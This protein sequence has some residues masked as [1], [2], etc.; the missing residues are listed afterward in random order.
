MN[1]DAEGG[2]WI[3]YRPQYSTAIQ[4]VST[5]LQFFRELDGKEIT[6]EYRERDAQGNFSM[7]RPTIHAGSMAPGFNSPVGSPVKGSQH[8]DDDVMVQVRKRV[9]VIERRIMLTVE[10]VEI[11]LQFSEVLNRLKSD[12][13][14][15][16]N[17]GPSTP[18]G[19][20]SS[21]SS[22]SALSSAM[23]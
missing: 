14:S 1:F 18:G 2:S 11:F 4:D 20:S 10:Q 7:R 23:H 13:K 9:Q 12:Y 8:A 15:R 6:F 17:G 5:S 22:S 16:I 21:S 19:V 3:D